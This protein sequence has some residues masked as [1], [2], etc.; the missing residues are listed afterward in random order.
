MRCTNCSKESE[1]SIAS[2][3]FCKSCMVDLVEKRIRKFIRAANYLKKEDRV[4]VIGKFADK[5]I[6]GI[7]KGLPLKIKIKEDMGFNDDPKGFIERL[8]KE[9]H[10]YDKI[11]LPWTAEHECCLFL[12]QML[13]KEADFSILGNTIRQKYI[14]L[15]RPLQEQELEIFAAAKGFSFQR[16]K[17]DIY[18]N[19]LDTMDRKYPE[20][21]FSLLKSIDDLAVALDKR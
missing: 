8:N 4:L 9:E 2:N 19:I 6:K 21:R 7:V 5:V 16:R 14:K 1:I 18:T 20:S 17:K 13:G 15:F 3:P 12:E 10:E 11:I